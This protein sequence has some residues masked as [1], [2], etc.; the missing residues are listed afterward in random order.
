MIPLSISDLRGRKAVHLATHVRDNWVSSAGPFVTAFEEQIA[1]LAERG[2]AVATVNGAAALHLA[3]IG[4]GVRKGD[5][6]VAPDWT[7]AASANAVHHAG[8]IP[9]FVDVDADSWN[10]SSFIKGLI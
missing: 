9:V 2:Y 8:A 4:V 10:F 3:L 6:V 5:H 1:T 7:F